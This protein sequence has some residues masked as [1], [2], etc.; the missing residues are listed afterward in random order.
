MGRPCSSRCSTPESALEV[1]DLPPG[2]G[3]AEAVEPVRP[4][5][6]QRDAH[7]GAGARVPRDA[8]ARVEQLV[9][10]V[11][12][13]APDHP[14]RRPRTSPP[15]FRGRHERARGEAVDRGLDD[16]GLRHDD[17][18]HDTTDRGPASAARAQGCD[19]HAAHRHR[20]TDDPHARRPEDGRDARTAAQR[21]RARARR[22]RR[23]RRPTA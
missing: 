23:A 2:D 20:L 5:V 18:A 22:A 10:L 11:P 14:G 6:Q 15:A 8:A 3:V 9:A 17:S 13:R 4:R 19:H 1:Y 21:A 16:A 7:R 12:Q